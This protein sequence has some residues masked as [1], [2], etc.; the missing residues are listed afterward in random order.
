MPT[1]LPIAKTPQ[2]CGD[3]S[4]CCF[5]L[6]VER[7]QKSSW[8][9]CEH[10]SKKKHCKLHNTE[11]RPLECSIYECLWLAGMGQRKDR[12]DRLGLVFDIP[13]TLH[14]PLY[15]GIQV[16]VCREVRPGALE[17]K[18]GRKILNHFQANNAVILIVASGKRRR[19][20]GKEALV[21]KIGQRLAASN[22]GTKELA[23]TVSPAPGAS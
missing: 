1:K 23:E 13:D 3:C 6:G 11:Q 5:V 10:H 16:A 9:A 20:T 21:M 7:L 12:P 2:T 4:A 15:E 14:S 22:A 18:R 17:S 8:Q 19:L